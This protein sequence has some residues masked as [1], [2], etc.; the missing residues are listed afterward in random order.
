MTTRQEEN[1]RW[2]ERCNLITTGSDQATEHVVNALSMHLQM[3]DL[4][5]LCEW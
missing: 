4:A 1:L 5:K 2:M 3:G